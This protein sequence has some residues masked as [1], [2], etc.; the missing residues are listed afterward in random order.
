MSVISKITIPGDDTYDVK[1]V[2][3]PFGQVDSTS[4][5]TAFTATIPGITALYDGVCMWL[6]NGVVSANSAKINVN[7]LGAKPIY[8]SKTGSQSVSTFSIASTHLFV[9]NSSRITGG[10]WDLVVGDD[11]NTTYSP[12]SLGFGY[13]TCSTAEATIAKAAT[14]SSYG[15]VTNGIVSVK[16]TNAVPANSTLNINSKGAKSIYYQGSA[17]TGGVIKAGDIATFIYSTQYHLIAIDRWGKYIDE[18]NDLARNAIAT[19]TD[20]TNVKNRIP[21]NFKT[22]TFR[23][24]TYT[25]NGDGT[26]TVNGTPSLAE[27]D[28]IVVEDATSSIV[29][30]HS[31]S[32]L[33]DIP[34][35]KYF[36][37]WGI[38]SP[39]S[40]VWVALY[41]HDGTGETLP[42]NILYGALG[43]DQAFTYTK[44]Q[45]RPYLGIRI[46]QKADATEPMDFTFKP[47]LCTK[48]E[49]DISD[50]FVPYAKTNREL[51]VAENEDRAA[52]VQLIDDGPKNRL[53]YDSIGTPT[54]PSTLTFTY[55]ADGSVTVNGITGENETA[56]VFLRYNEGNIDVK[57]FANGC[58]I[59]GVPSGTSGLSLRCNSGATTYGIDTGNGG[60]I[61]Y[62]GTAALRVL[63]FVSQNTT[64]VNVTVK[65]MICTKPEWDIS[66]AYVP[67]C[68]TNAEL[69]NEN[70]SQQSEINYAVNTGVKNLLHFNAIGSGVS[71][72]GNTYTHNGI[73]YTLN[74]DM[75]VTAT[76]TA[77]SDSNSYAYLILDGSFAPIDDYCDGEHILSGCPAN[78]STSKY[79]MYITRSGWG[80]LNETGSGAIIPDKRSYTGLLIACFVS[81][82]YAIPVG[83][84]LVF[85]PMIRSAFIT[86]TTFVPYAKTNSELAL[87][88][89]SQQSEI[90]HSV[91][92]GAKNVAVP[93]AAVSTT[94]ITVTQN[95]NGSYTFVCTN[96]AENRIIR[97]A[98][99]EDLP[100]GVYTFSGTTGGSSSTYMLG[101]YNTS[102]SAVKYQHTNAEETYTGN[103]SGFSLRVR[104]I[105]G[106]SG[107]FT[108]YPMIRPA[109]ITDSTFRPYAKTN[110]ELTA[111]YATPIPKN[112][113]L[114]NY[115]TGGIYSVENS[116]TAATILHAPASNYGYILEV[117][118]IS[119]NTKYQRI[120]IGGDIYTRRKQSSGWQSWYK[121]T[122][123]EV[124]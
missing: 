105:S 32:K 99:I 60:L 1:A 87:E 24:V 13:A 83:E 69:T 112:A 59:S 123:T 25:N 104:V 122:G 85:K 31:T 79:R 44:N 111:L 34:S 74:A 29:E 80:S 116:T 67:Y 97:V 76:G 16:F 118:S 119:D 9:Y 84:P 27:L 81:K 121:F 43:Y 5:S 90:N 95:A 73:T 35:G 101:L 19:I 50:A 3:I 15:L 92:T 113:D 36:M 68:K 61:Q 91:N 22:T 14:L 30:Y 58:I 64:L 56:Y 100:S 2:A 18:V 6:R 71:A 28:G 94:D 89:N 17:I 115:T 21:I 51:A 63:I 88:N 57:D 62:S 124:T 107:T 86:D 103:V 102:S 37:S 98:N 66:Q 55:N 40:D 48:A 78:G 4:T 114:N 45:T 53:I 54:A 8:Y 72:Y 33:V 77:N 42:F 82:G 96:V 108:V 7:N 106:Y 49:W 70:K 10:C 110:S 46:I 65:P 117:F 41:E 20:V 38:A 109:E 26:I 120:I 47:M 93:F 39:K 23:N 75:T 12:Q 52:I 11:T